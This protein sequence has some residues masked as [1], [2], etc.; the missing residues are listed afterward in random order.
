MLKGLGNKAKDSSRG[1][2]ANCKKKVTKA[3]K[4][5]GYEQWTALRKYQ[6]LQ[7]F[8]RRFLCRQNSVGLVY[9]SSSTQAFNGL[10]RVKA[11]AMFNDWRHFMK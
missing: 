6:L 10:K 3:N 7:K 4:L 2:K 9:I 11:K 5:I 8:V 1:V